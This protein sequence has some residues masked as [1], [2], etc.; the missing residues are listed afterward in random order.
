M[1]RSPSEVRRHPS[2]DDATSVPLQD[3]AAT[4]YGGETRLAATIVSIMLIR[5][6]GAVAQTYNGRGWEQVNPEEVT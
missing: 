3:V 1:R 4:V 6:N 5:G 2:S